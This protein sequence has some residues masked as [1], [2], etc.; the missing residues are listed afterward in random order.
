VAVVFLTL[1]F[2]TIIS[3]RWQ[4][5]VVMLLGYMPFAGVVT[6]SLYPSPLPVL[7]KD[8]F[9]VIPAYLFFLSSQKNG[10]S[11]ESIPPSIILAM[12]A[13]TILVLAQ[14][15]NPGVANWMVA[16][17]GIKVWLFYLP[18]IY[19]AY[20]MVKSREDLIWLLRLMVAI[21]CIPCG[22]GIAQW[23]ASMVFGYQTTMTSFYGDAAEGATQGFVSFDVGGSF[24]RIPSTFT[25][26]TQ[27]FGYT[28]AMIVP[29]YT[30][31]KMDPSRNW[32]KFATATLGLIILASFMSGARAAYLFVPILLLLIYVLEGKFMG[33]VKIAVML[34]LALLVAMSIGKIDPFM[35]F[36]LMTELFV[37][38]SYE[39]VE[40]GLL[41]SITT[42]PL[43]IGTGMNTGPARYAFEDPD[44]FIGIEN[45]YAK[46]VT[47]LGVIGLT[48]VVAL[49]LI[50]MS[51]GFRVYRQLHDQG[52]RSCSAAIL[53]FI[54]TMA[55]N[56]FKGWQIDLDP[57][58][59]YF[60]IFSGFI[61]K[62]DR[63]D[64]FNRKTNKNRQAVTI[65]N[66]ESS[67]EASPPV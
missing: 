11:K 38:Y 14:A 22:L 60:W 5:G 67:V 33:M 21:A 24:Y 1:A 45:Y 25:F 59:V 6:L 12:L 27:Y 61:L 2:S 42:E 19:L 31:M 7:F 63:L 30:L 49:F 10:L 28:L 41:D 20:A 34:P 4:R 56:S 54:V 51:H 44:S 47:E 16:A 9:F 18:L 66:Q 36:E 23:L 13:L 26:V 64:K 32:R 37:N 43:G 50:L 62:L 29:A 65:L 48:V 55:L 52:L 15:F 39:I 53:A 46:A 57:I 35:M 58:N 8:I 40:Q 17:I 3:L